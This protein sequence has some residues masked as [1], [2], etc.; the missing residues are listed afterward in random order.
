MKTPKTVK[1]L[2]REQAIFLD[3]VRKKNGVSGVCTNVNDA[4][5]LLL[6]ADRVAKEKE[7]GA[8]SNASDGNT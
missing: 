3:E 4:R 5:E 8:L 7:G 6:E 2:T 1:R